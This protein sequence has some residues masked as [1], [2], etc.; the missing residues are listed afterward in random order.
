MS[1]TTTIEPVLEA[2]VAEFLK[3][4]RAEA[5]FQKFYEIVRS[6][7]TELRAMRAFVQEDPDEEDR[8]AVVLVMDLPEELEFATLLA[9][10]RQYAERVVAEIPSSDAILFG[11]IT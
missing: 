8:S 10:R 6:A 2:G 7:F 5:P 11:L 3:E 4:H 1:T 9:Q